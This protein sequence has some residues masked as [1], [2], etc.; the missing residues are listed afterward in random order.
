M[1]ADIAQA[2]FDRA[3]NVVGHALVLTPLLEILLVIVLTAL[4]CL[5]L[6]RKGSIGV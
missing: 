3:K 6:E 1:I 2:F 5:A 4:L